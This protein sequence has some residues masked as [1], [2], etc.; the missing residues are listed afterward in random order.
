MLIR[1]ALA[2]V[3]VIFLASISACKRTKPE[4]SEEGIQRL[5]T[6]MPGM[7]EKCLDKMR[8][9]DLDPFPERTDQCFEMMKP[10]LWRGLWRDEFEGQRFCPAPARKCSEDDEEK[11]RIWISFPN[12]R[13]P[14][15]RGPTEKTYVIRFIGRR[16]LV[17]GMYGHMGMSE[18]EIIVDKLLMIAPMQQ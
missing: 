3:T 7:S 13:S 4:L 11:G 2:V 10:Q 8:M 16:T 15:G 5:R 6:A 18:H 9:G 1:L 14:N 12:H 17:P